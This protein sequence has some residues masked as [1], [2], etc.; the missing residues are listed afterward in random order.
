MHITASVSCFVAVNFKARLYPSFA[1]ASTRQRA[2]VQT[3]TCNVYDWSCDNYAMPGPCPA[4]RIG[5]RQLKVRRH[6]TV[7]DG[8]RNG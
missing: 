3:G 5:A 2:L 8:R 7:G 6:W 4:P 1:L